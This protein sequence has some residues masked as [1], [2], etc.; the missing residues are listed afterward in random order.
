LVVPEVPHNRPQV[1][2]EW[3]QGRIAVSPKDIVVAMRV[4]EP[5]VELPYGSEDSASGLDVAVWMLREGEDLIVG[6][7]LAEAFGQ[8]SG[9]GCA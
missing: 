6:R 2:V 1:R 9:G 8:R 5:R 4:G 3:D 7:R